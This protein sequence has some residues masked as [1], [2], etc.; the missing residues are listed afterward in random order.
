MEIIIMRKSY[1]PRR[2]DVKAARNIDKANSK[3]FQFNFE[4]L[5]FI[6]AG[7][8]FCTRILFVRQLVLQ[9]KELFF[10]LL[11]MRYHVF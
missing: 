1:P 6:V 11:F 9:L 4:S 2:F 8:L 3:I 5:P 10:S 7:T